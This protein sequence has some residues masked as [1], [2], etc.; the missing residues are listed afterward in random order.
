MFVGL[1][2]Y[3][4][5]AVISV[6]MLVFAKLNLWQ[7]IALSSY[8]GIFVIYFVIKSKKSNNIKQKDVN[9]YSSDEKDV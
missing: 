3:F 2:G 8:V 6:I 5:T 1:E 4:I 9:D 7:V